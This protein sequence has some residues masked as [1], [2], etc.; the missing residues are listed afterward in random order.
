MSS[1]FLTVRRS[2]Q[3]ILVIIVVVV[4][5]VVVVLAFVVITAICDLEISVSGFTRIIF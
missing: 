4:V 3:C 5:V 2:S 1:C